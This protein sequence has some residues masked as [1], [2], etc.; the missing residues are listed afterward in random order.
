AAAE[1]QGRASKQTHVGGKP[2]EDSNAKQSSG[3]VTEDVAIVVPPSDSDGVRTRD[4]RRVTVARNSDTL[5]RNS[6]V[7]GRHSGTTGR[8]SA[9]SGRH[10]GTAGRSS[11]TVARDS[12]SIK[13]PAAA[14]HRVDKKG[15]VVA[16]P[17][18]PGKSGK[19]KSGDLAV[20]EIRLRHV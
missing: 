15:T 14:R 3:I 13:P 4:I 7:S 16:I 8:D 12:T 10:S 19:L 2:S 11:A 5:A 6:A 18:E 9:T 1:L 17:D 20:F